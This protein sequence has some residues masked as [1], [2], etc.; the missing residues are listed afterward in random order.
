M[1]MLH[2]PLPKKAASV[3]SVQRTLD[4]NRVAG[5]PKLQFGKTEGEVGDKSK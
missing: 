3:L 1:V 2:F 4:I 5:R